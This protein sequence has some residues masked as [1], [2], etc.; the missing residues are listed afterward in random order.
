MLGMAISY[1]SHEDKVLED[2]CGTSCAS[3]S[4]SMNR[5]SNLPHPRS[6]SGSWFQCT[7][8]KSWRL[9]MSRTRTKQKGLL[10]PALSSRGGEGED[11][12]S[13]RVLACMRRWVWGKLL[14]P[15]GRLGR[16]GWTIEGRPLCN[17]NAELSTIR[18]RWF[19]GGHS[20]YFTPENSARTFERIYEDIR[21]TN[22]E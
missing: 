11:H 6:R 13:L 1:S 22:F 20:G 4:L 17:A 7:I 14:W 10:S 12:A 9:P 2:D 16:T 3:T 15:Y 18:T 8:R 21:R 5:P 19:A